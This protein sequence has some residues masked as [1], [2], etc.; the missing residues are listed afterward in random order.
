MKTQLPT[1]AA[2][3]AAL[4]LSACSSTGSSPI[5]GERVPARLLSN[6]SKDARAPLKI[7]ETN[8]KVTKKAHDN[9]RAQLG[10][11]EGHV[12]V[13]ME[14][15]DLVTARVDQARIALGVARETND[16]TAIQ[17]AAG[18]YADQL[19]AAR[20]MRLELAMNKRDRDV[21]MLRE[22]L[23]MEELRVAKEELQ[24]ARA[25]ALDFETIPPVDA[26]AVED[27]MSSVLFLRAEAK[28]A[29]TLLSTAQ[30]DR[31]AARES[32]EAARRRRNEAPAAEE[33]E[34][35]PAGDGQ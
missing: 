31:E 10:T 1:A 32:Y 27:L 30:L 21:A 12:A 29:E 13:A 5:G 9:A 23:T 28:A 4:L 22:R 19:E 7:A 3:C 35:A 8:V 20:L 18:A 26:V 24:L 17:E 11:E 34:P 33:A 16:E 2:L 6:V 14:K 25:E 15:L